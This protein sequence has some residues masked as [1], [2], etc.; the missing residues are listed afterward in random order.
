MSS[1]YCFCS[2]IYRS[3]NFINI[4]IPSF[5]SQSIAIGFAPDL[6]T[7]SKFEIIVKFGIITSSPFFKSKHLNEISKAAVPLDTVEAN[8]Y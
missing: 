1:Y 2:F 4:H 5:K 8:F 3:F 6:I 7:A